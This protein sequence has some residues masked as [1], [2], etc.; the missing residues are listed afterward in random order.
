MRVLVM[1]AVA[2]ERDAVQ[3][4]LGRD[5]RFEFALAGIGLVAAAVNGAIELAKAEYDLVVI[6]GIAGGFVGRAE[7]GSLVVSSE[8]IAADLGVEL[9]DG[10]SSLDELGFGSTRVGVAADAAERVTAALLA[11]GLQ[12][13]MAPVLTV[14]TATGTA[15]TAAKL[16]ARVPGAAAEAMEGF[17]IATA[18]QQRGVPVLEIRAISNAIG[19]RDRDAWRIGDALKALEAASSVLAEVL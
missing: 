4:G 18:A 5:S 8:I 9:L 17:G 12:A 13:Q 1:T 6:A 16:A 15:A 3:R 2:P 7:V 11:A 10:F 19:P 14:A